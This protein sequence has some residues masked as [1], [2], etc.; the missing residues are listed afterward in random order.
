MTF[1]GCGE[2]KIFSLTLQALVWAELYPIHVSSSADR[3]VI[4]FQLVIS[5]MP[6]TV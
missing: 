6:L 3:T 4:S 1:D 5:S 2:Y